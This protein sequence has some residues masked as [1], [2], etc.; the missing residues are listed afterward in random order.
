MIISLHQ[1]VAVVADGQAV[2]QPTCPDGSDE[3]C[4]QKKQDDMS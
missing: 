3:H 2:D 1:L 4:H